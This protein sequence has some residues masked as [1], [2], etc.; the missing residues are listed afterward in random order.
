MQNGKLDERFAD[1]CKTKSRK[2]HKRFAKR[3]LDTDKGIACMSYIWYIHCID[4][5]I[6]EL[7]GNCLQVPKLA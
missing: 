6:Y 4:A 1:K 7:Y 2:T 3:D 5:P